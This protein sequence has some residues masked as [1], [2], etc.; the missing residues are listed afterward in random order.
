M[1][2]QLDNKVALVIGSSK[3]LGFAIAERLACEGARVVLA[4][5]NEADLQAARD[6]ICAVTGNAQ[7]ASAGVL[8]VSDVN[9]IAAFF[10]Q[11]IGAG[12]LDILVTN[13]A[14]PK[15]G[16]IEATTLTDLDQA[17]QLLVAPVFELVKNALPLL[18]K[19]RNASVLA[20]TSM[21]VKQPIDGLLLSNMLRPSVAALMKSLSH[22][23]GPLGIRC[24]TIL[25][26]WIDT[27]RSKALLSSGHAQFDRA[28]VEQQIPL[29]RIGTP[30]E[31]A[32][33]ATFLVSPAASYVNGVM[34]AVDGGLITALS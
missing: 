14:G 5:R 8:D 33:A 20:I 29:R 30:E 26:G 23:L 1:Q 12:P 21:S 2:L 3:G 32:N 22:T 24:N 15:A 6:K 13:S 28:L 18:K 10:D 7:S 17:Y 9:S 16:N 25:P 34:L 19:S 31:F 4:G 27:D 11:H